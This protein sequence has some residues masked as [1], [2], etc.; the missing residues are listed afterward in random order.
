MNQAAISA[1]IVSFTALAEE[2]RRRLWSELEDELKD[3]KRMYPN[4]VILSRLVSGD[5][6]ELA[7]REP[8]MSLR[9]ALILKS[10]AKMFETKAKPVEKSRAKYFD[11]RGLR[12]AIGVGA[13]LSVSKETGLIDGEPIYMTGRKLQKQSTAG[14][15]KIFI[16][17]TLYFCSLDQN[18]NEKYELIFSFIDTLLSRCSK[19]QCEVLYYRLRGKAEEEIAGILGKSQSTVSQHTKLSGWHVID[20]ALEIYEREIS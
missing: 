7:L 2:D 1:D 4:Q 12:V 19:K 16:K 6:I 3:L 14:K 5:H 10:R 13:N 15:G 8:Q 18:W 17:D 11:E 9:M 20:K